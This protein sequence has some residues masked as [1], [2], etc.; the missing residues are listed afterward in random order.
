MSPNRKRLVASTALHPG[1]WGHHCSPADPGRAPLHQGQQRRQ[2]PA[3]L[4]HILR[5]RIMY[6][7]ADGSGYQVNPAITCTNKFHTCENNFSNFLFQPRLVLR[8]TAGANWGNAPVE[9]WKGTA[10]YFPFHK[11]L[12]RMLYRSDDKDEPVFKWEDYNQG[13]LAMVPWRF[14]MWSRSSPERQPRPTQRLTT[15]PENLFLFDPQSLHGIF[16]GFPFM[17]WKSCLALLE[18]SPSKCDASNSMYRAAVAHAYSG[19]GCRA[20]THF[21]ADTSEPERTEDAVVYS[22]PPT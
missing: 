17:L 7:T 12:P 1:V 11:Y 8:F 20:H 13:L 3:H 22:F 21:P 9:S 15:C 14:F 5:V 4:H 2:K 6:D 19:V 10:V 16:H 18:E